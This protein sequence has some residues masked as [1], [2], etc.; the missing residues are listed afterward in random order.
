MM[1]DKWQPI[2]TAPTEDGVLHVR[3]LCVHSHLTGNRLYFYAVAGY[4]EDGDFVSA[5]GGGFGWRPEDYTHWMPLPAEPSDE[6][7]K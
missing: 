5:S 6:A 4:L 7:E 1:T 3:A 2:E